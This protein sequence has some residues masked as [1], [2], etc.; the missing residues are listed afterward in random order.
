MWCPKCKNEYV[1]GITKCA[2][3]GVD[4][5]ESLEEFEASEAEAFKESLKGM[6]QSASEESSAADD[7]SN[8]TQSSPIQATHAYVS[9]KS[10]TEDLKSTAYTFTVVGIVG[11]ILLILFALDILPLHTAPYMKVMIS[12]VMGTMFIAFIFIGVRSFRQLKTSATE[13][14]DEE[15]LLAEV[16]TWFRGTYDKSS[17]DA[18]LDNSEPEETLYFSRYEVMRTFITEKYASIDE[19]LLDHIIETLYAEI[20]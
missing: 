5:V 6:Y 16:L 19:S 10:K 7:E 14:D 4:L 1:P 2:D 11:L 12:L 13:A 8:F 17:I 9:K 15:T 3:C 20:F 18:D